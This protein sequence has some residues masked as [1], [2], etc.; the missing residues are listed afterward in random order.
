MTPTA[1]VTGASSGIGA[2]FAR[3]LA[4][5]GYSLVLVARREALL[6]ALASEL[7]EKYSIK[8]DV[9]PADLGEMDGSRQVEACIAS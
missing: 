3:K 6:R 1:L 8:A 4:A 9:L 5:Q 7:Q 2:V